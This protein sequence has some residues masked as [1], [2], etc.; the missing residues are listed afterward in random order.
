MLNVG[1][2]REQIRTVV[3]PMF[4]KFVVPSSICIQCMQEGWFC[5]DAVS[6]PMAWPIWDYQDYTLIEGD[7]VVMQSLILPK[8]NKIHIA[9]LGQMPDDYGTN[10]RIVSESGVMT[11]SKI[12]PGYSRSEY[13]Y[14]DDG[15]HN[16]PKEDIIYWGNRYPFS[17][18]GQSYS[19]VYYMPGQNLGILPTQG[20]FDYLQASTEEKRPAFEHPIVTLGFYSVKRDNVYSTTRCQLFSEFDRDTFIKRFKVRVCVYLKPYTDYDKEISSQTQNNV[21]NLMQRE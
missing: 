5:Y 8:F 9:Y 19:T 10:H 2:V 6:Q 1:F 20:A 14:N 16:F 11:Y 7:K 4:M 12:H 3:D 15:Y 18:D 13:H 21:V 17:Y